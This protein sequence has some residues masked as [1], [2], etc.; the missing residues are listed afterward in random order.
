MTPSANVYFSPT[1]TGRPVSRG[2]EIGYPT[3]PVSVW[4]K[5]GFGSG[6]YLPDGSE[7]TKNPAATAS[8][9]LALYDK[10]FPVWWCV[11][12]GHY[13]LAFDG[14]LWR[15]LYSASA[16]GSDAVLGA[17]L[18]TDGGLFRNPAQ[19]NLSIWRAFTL[20]ADVGL[21]VNYFAPLNIAATL[22]ANGSKITF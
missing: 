8:L 16:S 12:E 17:F 5:N 22:T 2:L 14:A 4:A 11:D 13:C 9:P 10:N 1:P 6:A 7:W 15:L 18:S 3:T 20:Y 21:S 19:K